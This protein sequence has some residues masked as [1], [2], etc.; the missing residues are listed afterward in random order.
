MCVRACV[1]VCACVCVC[2]CLCACVCVVRESV[3]LYVC[4]CVCVCACVRVCVHACV[5]ACVL[6]NE[7]LYSAS[8][9]CR[10]LRCA[11]L[12]SEETASNRSLTSTP[13]PTHPGPLGPIV[14]RFTRAP[15]ALRCTLGPQD[16]IAHRCIPG[17]QD[18]QDRTAPR[19]TLGLPGTLDPQ[20]PLV[21]G[22][23]TTCSSRGSLRLGL[24]TGERHAE[25]V[26]V[27]VC[28]CVRVYVYV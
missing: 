7:K 25:S 3:S 8:S 2:A 14:P 12:L 26:C 28:V 22:S 4:A 24:N 21:E 15:T 18:L 9:C 23:S 16:P 19:C 6:L 27:C 20:F 5:R 17:P 10:T 11:R 13:D 1:R